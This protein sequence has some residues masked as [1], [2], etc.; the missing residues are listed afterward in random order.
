MTSTSA[1]STNL[2][3]PKLLSLSVVIPTLGDKSRLQD[4]HELAAELRQIKKS[5]WHDERRNMEI[6]IVAN[7]PHEELRRRYG[8]DPDFVYLEVGKLGANRARNK[9]LHKAQYDIVWFLDDDAKL[10]GADSVHRLLQAHQRFP[11]A[12]ALGGPYQIDEAHATKWDKVYDSIARQWIERSRLQP[13]YTRQ[14]LGGNLSLK[15]SQLRDEFDEGLHFG[16]SEAGL[17]A[18]LH[19]SQQ[20]LVWIEDLKVGHRPQVSLFSFIRKAYLQGAGAKWLQ[21]N[22]P[23]S[24]TQHWRSV[25]T[26]PPHWLYAMFFQFGFWNDAYSQAPNAPPRLP[27]LSFGYWML[28]TSIPQIWK[29]PRRRHRE[30][31]V[32]LKTLA[33]ARRPAGR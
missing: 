16:G 2:V 27:W 11:E 7:L 4:L 33:H 22:L 20:K 29:I 9:G 15:R 8:H 25:Q 32:A 14:L 24:R 5:M 19:L 1:D 3:N 13:P 21:K 6:L 10:L 17:C 30:L 31:Y 26:E 12:V 28:K 18:R 23:E